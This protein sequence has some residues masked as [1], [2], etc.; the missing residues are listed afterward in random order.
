M[1]SPSFS[2]WPKPSRSRCS[3]AA[4]ALTTVAKVS[5]SF[6]FD[7]MSG[8]RSKNG[9]TRMMRSCRLLTTNTHHL[10]LPAIPF[11]VTA[12]QSFLNQ[13]QHFPPVAVLADMKF[14]NEL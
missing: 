11:D 8:F 2:I 6:C 13:N 4:I 14:G 7:E 12:V 1:D 10:V 3:P 9:I 5:N